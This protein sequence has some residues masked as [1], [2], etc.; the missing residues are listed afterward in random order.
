MPS[1]GLEPVIPAL[2]RPQTYALDCR[3]LGS[4]HIEHGDAVFVE[5]VDLF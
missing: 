3:P 5:R 4:A 2:E 1:A